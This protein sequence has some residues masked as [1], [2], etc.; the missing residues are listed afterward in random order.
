[1]KLA[2]WNINSIRA[3][4]D[5]LVPWVEGNLPDVLCLQETKVDD[6]SFPSDVFSS[7]GYQAVLYGQRTYNGVALLSR[8]PVTDVVRGFGDQDPEARF[9][10]GTIAGIQIASVYVPNGRAVGSDKFLYKLNWLA[11]LRRWLQNHRSPTAPLALCGDYNV[12]PEERD[13]HDPHQWKDQVLFH[14]EERAAVAR[15][16]EWGLTDVF[17]LHH[18]AGGLFS[19]WDYRK[20][21]FPKNRGLRIDYMLCTSPLAQACSTIKMD[22]EARKGKL[23]SDHAPVVAEF[24]V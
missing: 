16:K 14:P 7:L 10:A 11:R 20:L 5:R 15:L 24:A 6:A 12:A 9:I 19:W 13:V 8:L 21:S 4:L 2:S 18:D 3:R 23:P 1:M 22:R 17:R